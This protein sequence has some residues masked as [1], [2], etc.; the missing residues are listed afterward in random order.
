MLDIDFPHPKNACLSGTGGRGSCQFLVNTM[1]GLTQGHEKRISV[2]IST[3]RPIKKTHCREQSANHQ[4]SALKQLHPFIKS[5]NIR[6]SPQNTSGKKWPS[7]L[8]MILLRGASSNMWESACLCAKRAWAGH[9]PYVKQEESHVC[10]H[11]GV[12]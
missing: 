6:Q 4:A 9:K 3:P 1:Q 11:S 12:S 2:T 8:N 7:V 5:S 10:I